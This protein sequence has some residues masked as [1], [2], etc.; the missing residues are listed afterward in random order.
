MKRAAVDGISFAWGASA[1]GGGMSGLPEMDKGWLWVLGGALALWVAAYVYVLRFCTTGFRALSIVVYVL[2]WVL[3]AAR[4][5]LFELGSM[6][7]DAATSLSDLLLAGVLI[8]VSLGWIRD[9]RSNEE[10]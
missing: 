10:H 5:G 1:R 8:L 6:P 7:Q 2:A 3:I 4:V 9:P